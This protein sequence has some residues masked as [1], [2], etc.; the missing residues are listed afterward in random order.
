[1]SM[2]YIP[3]YIISIS[4]FFLRTKLQISQHLLSWA[5]VIL[6]LLSKYSLSN[7]YFKINHTFELLSFWFSSRK[8]SENSSVEPK[9]S[10]S[11]NIRRYLPKVIVIQICSSGQSRPWWV[12]GENSSFH[13]LIS[14][15]IIT[16][17]KYQ[18]SSLHLLSL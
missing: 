14:T 17:Y 3:K 18:P 13:C 5:R 6:P 1:M 8:A 7:I 12:R 15:S 10:T 9:F 16:V 2:G 4:L 11:F